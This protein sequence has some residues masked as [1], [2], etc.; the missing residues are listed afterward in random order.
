MKQ[1]HFLKV[2]FKSFIVGAVTCLCFY[3]VIRVMFW[4]FQFSLT[5]ELANL[6]T[7]VVRG[8]LMFTAAAVIFLLIEK[9]ALR[10]N[11][12]KVSIEEAPS[13]MLVAARQ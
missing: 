1:N 2:A 7:I 3:T 4:D 13:N 5:E 10:F 8:G 6:A 9:A 12:V 11:L